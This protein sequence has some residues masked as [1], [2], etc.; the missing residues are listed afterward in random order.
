[1]PGS[2]I[3]REISRKSDKSR[4]CS[5]SRS[6]IART[7]APC[8]R[9]YTRFIKAIKLNPHSTSDGYDNRI[10]WWLEVS[11]YRKP[12]SFAIFW[13]VWLR[14]YTQIIIFFSI[15]PD[16]YCERDTVLS[17]DRGRIDFQISSRRGRSQNLIFVTNV[18]SPTAEAWNTDFWNTLFMNVIWAGASFQQNLRGGNCPPLPDESW[19]IGVD[20]DGHR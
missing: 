18:F 11:K 4:S 2:I 10:K 3:A 17:F 5:P 8:G 14:F 12:Y 13:P 20:I 19:G 6:I 9:P 15:K 7:I 16:T 1:M